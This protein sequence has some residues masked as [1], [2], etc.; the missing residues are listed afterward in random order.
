MRFV[1][2][3]LPISFSALML[4]NFSPGLVRRVK[5]PLRIS[6]ASMAPS[7]EQTV[8]DPSGMRLP[9]QVTVPLIDSLPSLG[10]SPQPET[11][12]AT[13]M[14]ANFETEEVEECREHRG[15]VFCFFPIVSFM[16]NVFICI[17][18]CVV[19]QFQTEIDR[20]QNVL[21]ARQRPILENSPQQRW[22]HHDSG[23][24]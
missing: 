3:G 19:P 6:P 15:F 8:I 5:T 21:G 1:G 16:S 22:S 4:T 12:I 24:I 11:N 23:F 20:L 2:D 18:I 14:I 7:A 9:F 17:C 13:R 10:G